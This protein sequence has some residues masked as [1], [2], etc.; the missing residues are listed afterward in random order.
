LCSN[1]AV[2]MLNKAVFAK[3]DFKYP[4]ALSSIHMA[5]NIIGAQLY[6]MF[7]RGQKPK[8][9]EP[10]SRKSILAFS[11]IFSLNIAIG[12]SSLQLVSVNFNQVARS[13]VPVLVMFISIFYFRRTY[14]DDRKWAVV[15][16]VI[17][18]ATAFYGDLR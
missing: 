7:A 16:I 1:I 13:L 9:L 2:T 15:P 17:G 12:N 18:V 6:F 14:S 4:Y 3:V 5:C 11:V 8:V 10:A